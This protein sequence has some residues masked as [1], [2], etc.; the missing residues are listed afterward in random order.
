MVCCSR[1]KEFI[2][3]NFRWYCYLAL[4][5][6]PM[7]MLFGPRHS[8]KSSFLYNGSWIKDI[9]TIGFFMSCLKYISPN[10]KD[11][12]KYTCKVQNRRVAKTCNIF[13]KIEYTKKAT[14]HRLN[15]LARFSLFSN[16]LVQIIAMSYLRNT[17][18]FL[19]FLF[20][21]I[22]EISTV[23]LALIGYS[24]LTNE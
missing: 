10:Q 24:C 4:T 22:S 8:M 6:F 7:I 19:G 18:F 5:Q 14:E 21:C 11:N 12:Y 9:L 13:L 2:V 16:F 3:S 1:I 15:S 23:K 20:D 17:T